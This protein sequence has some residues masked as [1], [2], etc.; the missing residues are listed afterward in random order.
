MKNDLLDSLVGNGTI[1]SYHYVNVSEDGVEGE[2]SYNRN[3]EK[4]VIVF[5]TNET[6]TINTFCSGCAEDTVMDIS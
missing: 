2:E 3:T 5:N 1:Q 6:L 4:L